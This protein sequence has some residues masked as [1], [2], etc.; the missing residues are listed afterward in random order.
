MPSISAPIRLERPPLPSRQPADHHFLG[1]P[2]LVLDPRGRPAA[3]LIG[4][5]PL[6]CDHSFPSLIAGVLQ[7]LGPSPGADRERSSPRLRPALPATA[8]GRNTSRAT[9]TGRPDGRCRMPST[10]P[11]WSARGSASPRNWAPPL[12][13][14]H[15][16]AVEDHLVI[17]QVGGHRGELRI[18][19]GHIASAPGPQRQR[20]WSASTSTR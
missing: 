5:V 19:R 1:V 10:R 20:P 17:G 3:G 15:R 11:E 2:D 13:E 4:G 16:L 18:F 7:R 14:R 9:E 12:V 6:L 8:C